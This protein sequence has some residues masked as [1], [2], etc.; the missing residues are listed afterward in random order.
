MVANQVASWVYINERALR[1]R[2]VQE[3]EE[4]CSSGAVIFTKGDIIMLI[5]RAGDFDRTS[6]LWDSPHNLKRMAE[7]QDDMLE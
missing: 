7:M 4:K 3:L 2:Y 1:Q 6:P 5:R